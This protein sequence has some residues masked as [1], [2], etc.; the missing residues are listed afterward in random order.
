MKYQPGDDV[1]VDF[2]GRE[3]RGEILSVS[4]KTGYVLCNVII[5]PAWDYGSITARLAP[6]STVAV[7]PNQLKPLPAND[8]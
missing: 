8:E 6:V 3:T 5:D 4:A 1:L 2:D 7:R